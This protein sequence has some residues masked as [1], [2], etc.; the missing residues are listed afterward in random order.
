MIIIQRC[1]CR[2]FLRNAGQRRHQNRNIKDRT[3]KELEATN[4]ECWSTRPFELLN[5]EQETQHIWGDKHRGTQHT[6][7]ARY[8][9]W[10]GI[11]TRHDRPCI[12]DT[13]YHI[14]SIL[15]TTYGIRDAIHTSYYRIDTHYQLPYKYDTTDEIRSTI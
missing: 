15:D 10:S 11:A 5:H 4:R 6:A 12:R 3:M 13:R 14:D 8:R 7:S 9:L 1:V 2:S